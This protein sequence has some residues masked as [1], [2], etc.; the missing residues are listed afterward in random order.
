MMIS[1]AKY[2]FL[3]PILA[4]CIFLT[5]IKNSPEISSIPLVERKCSDKVNFSIG[6]MREPSGVESIRDS[7]RF[8]GLGWIWAEPCQ[9]GTLTITAEGEQAEGIDPRLDI[10]L[11]GKLFASKH[12]REKRTDTIYIPSGG[13]L[14]LAFVNDL[15]KADVRTAI[16]FKPRMEET[17][18]RAVKVD[19]PIDSAAIWQPEYNSGSII[20]I[21]PPIK[22]SPCSS[23][24][25]SINLRGNTVLEE[26]PI[27]S[28]EQ[29]GKIL[30]QVRTLNE[31]R[32][33][34]F[35]ASNSPIEAR[36]INPYAKLISDRN[37][38][39]RSIE[40]RNSN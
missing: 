28:F 39:I 34:K 33:Y 37:L 14:S 36:M 26:N 25:F 12:F 29:E 24:V 30:Q 6:S 27:I 10:S 2:I 40:F 8:N 23:G 32:E 9:G 11:N 22:F 5:Q 31:F 3:L 4:A 7:F 1:K 21:S 17:K 38:Y 15:F 13:F 19:I 18:C 35:P 16:F 20:R